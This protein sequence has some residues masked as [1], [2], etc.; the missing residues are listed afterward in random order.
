MAISLI[1]AHAHVTRVVVASPSPPIT[2]ASLSTPAH[3]SAEVTAPAGTEA[4]SLPF[5][6]GTT[7]IAS[8]SFLKFFIGRFLFSCPLLSLQIQQQKG[9]KTN[10]KK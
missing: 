5:V 6:I 9:W 4:T 1:V 10:T 7:L 8:R 3:P 2:S